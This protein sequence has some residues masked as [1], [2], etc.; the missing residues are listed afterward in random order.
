[1]S[2]LVF[3]APV[4]PWKIQVT[5]VRETQE[6]CIRGSSSRRH[7]EPF[8]VYLPPEFA[9]TLGQ[10][11]TREAILSQAYKTLQGGSNE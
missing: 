7:E 11:L 1:M 10:T 5:R 4:G 6:L 8:R 3:E 9:L 2:E